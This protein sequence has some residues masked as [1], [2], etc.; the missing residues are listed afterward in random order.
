VK[1]NKLSKNSHA[2]LEALAEGRS[3]EEILAEDP[4]LACHDIFRAAAEMPDNQRDVKWPK[5]TTEGRQ[6]HATS[7]WQPARN[8]AITRAAD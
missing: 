4:T 6:K 2:I 8:E 1:S 5:A 3:C 7:G